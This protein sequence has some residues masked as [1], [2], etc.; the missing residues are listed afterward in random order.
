M[1]S[2]IEQQVMAAVGT[3]YMARQLVSAT[4]IKLYVC[5]L[6]LFALARLVWVERVF[7]NLSEASVGHVAQ[8]ILSAVINTD[9]LVQ[10][11]LLALVVT[12]LSL[13]RDLLRTIPSRY[14]L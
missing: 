11:A 5:A 9:V 12:G 2:K 6:A 1:Q 14:A 13:M 3:T 4:A 8:F 10:V 7:A